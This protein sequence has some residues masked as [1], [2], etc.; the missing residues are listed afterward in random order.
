MPQSTA[1]LAYSGYRM[2]AEMQDCET[3]WGCKS[4]RFY[5]DSPCPLHDQDP[6]KNVTIF[7]KALSDHFGRFRNDELG[8]PLQ[9]TIFPASPELELFALL[10]NGTVGL[11][12]ED[13]T[14]L[15]AVN[16]EGRT[17]KKRVSFLGATFKQ[18]TSF[19]YG[20]FEST[21]SFVGATFEGDASFAETIYEDAVYFDGIM[22]CSRTDFS[23]AQFKTM[24]SFRGT[25]DR[26]LLAEA[27]EVSF[28][29][30]R[31][32]QPDL[33]R[34]AYVDFKRCSLLKADLR[35][36]DFSGVR[37]AE[38]GMWSKHVVLYTRK[39]E[40]QVRLEL[41][42]AYRQ[43]RQSYE[44]RR[45]YG[46]AGAF[47]F[48]EMEQKWKGSGGFLA[49]LYRFSSNY[50]HSPGRAFV[51]LLLLLV[52]DAVLV[53]YGGIKPAAAAPYDLG[54]VSDGGWWSNLE[55]WWNALWFFVLKTVTFSQPMVVPA[56]P[57]V[58]ALSS[59]MRIVIS[60]QVALFVLAVNRKFKR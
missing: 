13:A 14:F 1:G 49:T 32:F 6:E 21:V 3:K 38:T 37:W 15:G 58:D 16:F 12:L 42:N 36:I 23:L 47:Y 51:V 46:R 53:A 56:L 59:L 48:G 43:I 50:G 57:F 28:D 19:K 25:A 4:K 45:D 22:A 60:V 39:P 17:F 18:I 11:R 35:G 20:R 44:D 5:P 41:E 7:R 31:F 29:E 40:E 52:L 27:S 30:V 33:V 9:G 10:G 54:A 2:Q 24:V 8:L 26:L 55:T 34:L